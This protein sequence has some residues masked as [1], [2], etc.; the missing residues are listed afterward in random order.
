[1]KSKSKKKIC[2]VS[3]RIRK[4]KYFEITSLDDLLI[5]LTY[6]QLENLLCNYNDI[7]NDDIEMFKNF[8]Q[9][10]INKFEFD[11]L[12]KYKN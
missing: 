2:N 4:L 3:Y 12:E 7:F 11:Q 10:I 8:K 9:L 5:I 6:F 1:M